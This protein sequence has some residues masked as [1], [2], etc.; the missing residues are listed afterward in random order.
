MYGIDLRTGTD[1]EA[2]PAF[3]GFVDLACG[4]GC[5][6]YILHSEGYSGWGF[7]ARSRKT[8]DAF[9]SEVRNCLKE[10]L[11]I[12]SIIADGTTSSS[13]TEGPFGDLTLE[14][15]ENKRKP[16]I[17]NGSFP[18]HTFLISNHADE[19]TSW[20]PLLAYLNDSPFIAIPCCSHAL[21]GSKYRYP[22]RYAGADEC[23][24]KQPNTKGLGKE[25]G[26]ADGNA[27]ADVVG[28]NGNSISI[29]PVNTTKTASGKANASKKGSATT[30]KSNPN[31]STSAYSTLC[32]YIAQLTKELGYDAE[33]EVLRIPSTRNVCIVGLKRTTTDED[34]REISGD[35]MSEI[36]RSREDVL[37]AV[38]ERDAQQ[39]LSA[40]A[41]TFRE[42]A[43]GVYHSKG[44]N[45]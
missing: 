1:K 7:D 20:T 23:S 22:G 18:P 33:K 37:R 26:H 19:L 16:V 41:A 30:N 45:H 13:G 24:D 10:M 43:M 38:I 39:T 35:D 36:A 15:A 34:D 25:R 6:V 40:V 4:N 21:D 12:P 14:E 42:R 32:G 31:K 29:D 8:W 27:H 11:L 28:S 5:L 44:R 2:R 17:H 9:P 3:P